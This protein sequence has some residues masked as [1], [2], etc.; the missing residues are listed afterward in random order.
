MTDTSENTPLLRSVDPE[1][2]GEY[3]SRNPPAPNPADHSL[4]FVTTLTWVSLVLSVFV[5]A[6]GLTVNVLDETNDGESYYIPWDLRGTIRIIAIMALSTA[7]ISF[8]NLVRLRQSHRALWLWLNLVFDFVI[9][10]YAVLG[11]CMGMTRDWYDCSPESQDCQL[12]RWVKLF[13]SVTFGFGFALG[14]NHLILFLFRCALA[15]Q[16]RFWQRLQHLRLPA[17]QF[18]V[19]FTVK[20]LRQEDQR[21]EREQSQ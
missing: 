3:E 20:F 7:L 15:F 10:F 2:I 19:E 4:R 16:S 13:I 1:P 11:S 5:V 14:I 12:A 17:G 18:T 8:L 6:F 9:A 21:I